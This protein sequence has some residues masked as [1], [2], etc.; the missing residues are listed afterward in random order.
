M[1]NRHLVTN[2][3]LLLLL[4][5]S[6]RAIATEGTE[7]DQF[8]TLLIDLHEEL[9]KQ[10]TLGRNTSQDHIL[11]GECIYPADF[12]SDGDILREES[13][14]KKRDTGLEIR[15]GYNTKSLS[16]E[17]TEDS[18]SDGKG[19]VELSWDI[20]KEGYLQHTSQARSYELRAM[21][22]DLFRELQE[23]E[24]LVLCRRQEIQRQFSG[25]LMPAL[26]R[27]L[28]LLEPVYAIERRAYFKQWSYLDDYLVSE[29]DL[30]LTRQELA[31]LSSDP[32]FDKTS[33]LTALPPIIVVD[34]G[35]L[36]EKVRLDDSFTELH[37][38]QKERLIAED[39]SLYE[40]SF[41]V[42]LRQEFDTG[43][44]GS[45]NNLIAGMRF[46]VP[47]HTR[48]SQLLDLQLRKLDR[49]RD[50]AAWNRIAAIR[51]TFSELQEQ[52]QRTIR[53]QYRHE[54][55]AERVRQTLE[56]L[57]RGDTDILTTAITRMKTLLESEVERIRAIEL[58]YNKTNEVFRAANIPYQPELVQDISSSRQLTRARPGF[59]S[60]YIWSKDFYAF[61][62]DDLLSFLEAKSI[63][64]VLLS[65]GRKYDK[66][67]LEDFLSTA[68]K[69][70]ITVELIVGDNSWIF[71]KKK[72]E[73]VE[74]SLVAAET[75]GY[76]HL[77]IEPQAM[78]EY[79]EKREE[80]LTLYLDMIK[81]MRSALLDRELSVAVPFHWPETTYRELAKVTDVI[82]LMA[83]GTSN[84]DTMVKR[85]VRIRKA[86][87]ATKLVVVLNAREFSD[88]WALEQM[89][90]GITAR[91][92]ITMFGIHDLGNFIRICGADHAAQN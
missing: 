12:S 27:Q 70:S 59:R 36:L 49:K 83:Y 43:S 28:R 41:R 5:F 23:N 1:E 91:T 57:K 53:Q 30:L 19:N 6:T 74:K 3:A 21:E 89:I 35:R 26:R 58:L 18:F 81:N 82:Y 60:I 33:S 55:A 76:L 75:T 11:N 37:T 44:S 17:D 42:Y 50:S 62:N 87:P 16:G 78:D 48:E 84:L 24:N 40:D 39:Y 63:S 22:A 85:I 79:K 72:R 61:S 31:Y 45:Q 67:K 56:L 38:L 65:T 9:Y 77:D 14:L 86:V 4:I 66:E 64:T 34:L 54:R 47:L 2:I 7:Y 68:Q 25:L 13:R 52:L 88:E 71:I 10:T 15:G 90:E 20:L 46:T 8:V 80:Y 32:L 29:Q 73:A 69:R 92:D 51:S